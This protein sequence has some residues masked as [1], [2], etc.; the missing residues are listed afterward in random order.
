M[1]QVVEVSGIVSN[2]KRDFN[3]GPIK[4]KIFCPNMNKSFETTCDLFCP[5]QD[6]DIINAICLYKKEPLSTGSGG[7]AGTGTEG[8]TEKFKETLTVTRQPFVQP[9]MDKESLIQ[10][11]MRVLK[12]GFNPATRI[13]NEFES[14]ATDISSRND[15][16][17]A[18]VAVIAFLTGL[19]QT[20]NDTH[21]PKIFESFKADADDLQKLLEWW[22]K[23]RNMR[24]LYLFGLTKK[25]I[26]SA[27]LTCDEIY[28][29]CMKNPYLVPSIPLEKADAILE[30]T[31]KKSNS[32]EWQ[33]ERQRGSILR[34]LFKNLN[35]SGWTGTP[36]GLIKKQFPNIKTHVEAL[37]SDY[38]L[39][40]EMHTL[41]LPHPN[42]VEKYVANFI[43]QKVQSDLVSYHSPLDVELNPLL[44][45]TEVGSG[46][47]SGG[48][49]LLKQMSA[50][51]VIRYS[52]HFTRVLSDD[53]IKAVQGALDH[54]LSI[55]TGGAGTGKTTVLGQIV[56]NLKM[57]KIS[58]ALCSFTGKA[59][60]RIREVTGERNAS[61]IHRLIANNKGKDIDVP[62][63]GEPV[64][65]LFKGNGGSL[66]RDDGLGYSH[67]I[68]DEASMV[69]IELFYELITTFPHV[70]KITL[71]G[72]INQLSPIGW[73]ALLAQIVKSK[74]V[75]T[76]R[77]TINHRVY[78]ISGEKD[79]IILN[80]NAIISHDP[81]YPFEFVKT[82][83]FSFMPGNVNRVFDIV[84]TLY[85]S[86]VKIDIR[87]VVVITPY[88]LYLE[89][90]NRTVQGIY[91]SQARSIT[92]SRGNK[93][94]LGD[95]V[96]LNE[97][98]NDIG[99]Y[100]GEE[101]LITDFDDNHITVNFGIGG[102]HDFLLEPKDT[103]GMNRGFKSLLEGGTGDA[104][105]KSDKDTGDLRYTKERTVLKLNLSYALTVD[106]SQGSEWDYTIL[107]I[108][109]DAGDNSFL[110]KNRIYTA[111][112]RTKKCCWVIS[113]I[114]LLEKS[115][116][117]L[118]SYRCDN[119]HMRLANEL[120]HMELFRIPP[121]NTSASG[122]GAVEVEN[123]LHPT[124]DNFAPD[125]GYDSA[126]D[127]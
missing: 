30:M 65:G 90:L 123:S 127:N 38:K 83:N 78:Q 13:Y 7:R 32:P 92:D 104:K 49:A 84:K 79:G 62:V 47:G 4:F 34:V 24:R 3:G 11:F 60:A 118:P 51:S 6:N 75:P 1:T 35:E 25:E 106:K 88:N 20:W 107:F 56:H 46:S 117:R 100:N 40:P 110:N 76:Y 125:F 113:D 102:V 114:K 99:V 73:G 41:Y 96:M 72:D 42:K 31:N 122:A 97:N 57:R 21:N 9:A 116:A 80:A 94:A 112:T 68:I 82:T 85:E 69:T 50:Q 119:L 103:P 70:D 105:F 95:K 43:I 37:K 17:E 64:P 58:Y 10:C 63:F 108:P 29:K 48:D 87:D 45:P 14:V 124:N 8:K 39:V 71:V 74:T 91:N 26:E 55:V 2:I 120:P 23:D 66:D 59:V 77:L 86:P 44:L 36:T 67:I 115:A 93:W 33:S 28:Q 89:K 81:Q 111:I 19:A 109:P 18:S 15:K 12:Y 52:A 126:D 5:L 53:Q 27:K 54:K 16:S 98:D 61:T 101:G 22:Y 121:V